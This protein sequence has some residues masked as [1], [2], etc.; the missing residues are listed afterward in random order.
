VSVP[1]TMILVHDEWSHTR[2][3]STNDESV[4]TAASRIAQAN[5]HI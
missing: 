5:F 1:R 3:V 2:V 4:T